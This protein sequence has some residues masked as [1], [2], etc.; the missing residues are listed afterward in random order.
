LGPFTRRFFLRLPI[1][2]ALQL[3][4]ITRFAEAVACVLLL[5]FLTALLMYAVAFLRTVDLLPVPLQLA[6]LALI[7]CWY[8]LAMFTFVS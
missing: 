2:G 5:P 3:R 7:S 8:A 1:S 6:A 4:F